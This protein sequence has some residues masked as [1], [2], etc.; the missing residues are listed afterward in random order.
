[1]FY[2]IGFR[3]YAQFP[4][5]LEDRKVVSSSTIFSVVSS[6]TNFSVV[7]S[8]TISSVVSYSTIFSTPT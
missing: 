8:S 1:M 3:L 6:S 7:S 5:M 2:K 4:A